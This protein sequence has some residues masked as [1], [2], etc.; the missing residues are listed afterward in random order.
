MAI[1]IDP[2]TLKKY[3]SLLT[4]KVEVKP[5]NKEQLRNY[6]INEGSVFAIGV[7]IVNN[8]AVDSYVKQVSSKKK[9][10]SW[11]KKI[12][13]SN[14]SKANNKYKYKCSRSASMIPIISK[15]LSYQPE[16]NIVNTL[17]ALVST[18]LF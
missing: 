16:E 9:E 14:I 1:P 12:I 17:N 8:V 4:I 10:V 11:C 3:S 5:L 15:R 7:Y 6:R 13:E 2:V 18:H